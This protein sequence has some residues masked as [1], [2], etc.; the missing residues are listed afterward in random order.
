[1]YKSTRQEEKRGIEMQI[2][3][4]SRKTRKPKDCWCLMFGITTRPT[5]G[6]ETME[7]YTSPKRRQTFGF[8]YR[9][10]SVKKVKLCSR[11]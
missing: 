5:L 2:V 9:V 8:L 3:V 4:A 10:A 6:H 1:M 7:Q 11:P